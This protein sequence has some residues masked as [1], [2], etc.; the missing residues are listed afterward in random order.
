M[1]RCV[2]GSV[3]PALWSYL[4]CMM[5]TP[6]SVCHPYRKSHPPYQTDQLSLIHSL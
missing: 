4:C 3:H 5:L 6:W 1:Q 2:R